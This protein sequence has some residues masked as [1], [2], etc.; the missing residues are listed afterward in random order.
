MEKS[1]LEPI[2]NEITFFMEKTFQFSFVYIAALFATVA[3][4][5]SDF[6]KEI[7]SILSSNS[8][9]HPLNWTHG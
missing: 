1:T 2:K 6:I 5:N 3:G 4:G 9:V 7:A 8:V